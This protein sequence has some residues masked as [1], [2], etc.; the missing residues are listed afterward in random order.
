MITVNPD[1]IVMPN[2]VFSVLHKHII[3]KLLG[4]ELTQELY[5]FIAFSHEFASKAF[6]S[7][8]GS[9]LEDPE[10]VQRMQS[11]YQKHGFPD[12]TSHDVMEKEVQKILDTYF[13]RFE[14]LMD[15]NEGSFTRTYYAMMDEEYDEI[16]H[17]D[18]MIISCLKPERN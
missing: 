18:R 17:H 8:E 5:A 14:S 9:L 3:Q 2:V 10:L 12:L 15:T 11:A 13:I 1:K 7:T 4:Q 16:P 6:L